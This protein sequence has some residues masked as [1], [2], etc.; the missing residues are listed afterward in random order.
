M[1]SSPTHVYPVIWYEGS[2]LLIDQTHLPAEYA[3]VEI[4]RCEDMAQ[5]IKTMIVRG[6]PAIGIAA[7]YGMYLG[8]REIETQDREQFLSQLE[9]VAQMLRTTRPTAVNLFW[10]ISRM[11]K[12]AYETIGTVEEIR[13][14]LL[15]TAQ[16]IQ[17]E[18]LQ[19]CQAIGDRG[20]ELLPKTPAQL[21]LLTHCNAGALA[22][23][24]YGTALG[25]VRS[26]WSCGRLSR[27]YAD[28]TRPRLQGAK[29]TAWECVQEGIPVTV[30]T[31]SMAAHCMQ[32]GMIHAVVVGADRIAANGD[33]ANKIGTYSLALV[34]KAHDVPFY[35]AAPVATID[36]AIATG[37][38]IPIEERDPVEV[39]QID[40]TILTPAGVEFYNPAFDVTPAHLITAIITEHGAF[41]PSQLQQELQHKYVA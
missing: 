34:A 29:L 12:T 15:T 36:F 22:T 39:Y 19:T 8:A 18:D 24:G 40:D 17:T 21:N 4:H 37:R 33:T 30:I 7:A 25:V 31:D 28:E 14:V 38:E 11:L 26:A 6:A 5:A 2:V 41:S 20:L 16:T 1:I 13:Q 10:A 9:Q 23:A 32:Q 27:L 35:V 3:F